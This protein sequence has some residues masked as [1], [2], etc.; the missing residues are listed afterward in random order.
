MVVPFVS[1]NPEAKPSLAD[2]QKQQ[3]EWTLEEAVQMYFALR[4]AIASCSRYW[5]KH[6]KRLPKDFPAYEFDGA[7]PP[8]SDDDWTPYFGPG[9]DWSSLAKFGEPLEA[10]DPLNKRSEA[11]PELRTGRDVSRDNKPR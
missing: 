1:A 8:V 2:Y 6:G 5:R 9:P 10:V 3:E 7:P 4:E 11:V